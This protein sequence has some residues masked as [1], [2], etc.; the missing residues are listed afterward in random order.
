MDMWTASDKLI[1]ACAERIRNCN[2]PSGQEIL[3]ISVCRPSGLYSYVTMQDGSQVT[4]YE[5]ELS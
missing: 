2:V 3:A 1:K 5:R 4:V